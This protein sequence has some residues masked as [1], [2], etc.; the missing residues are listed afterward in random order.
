MSRM[1]SSN[2]LE[3]DAWIEQQLISGSRLVKYVLPAF[4]YVVT[5]II[6]MLLAL[7]LVLAIVELGAAIAAALD[8]DMRA[9]SN[10]GE[11]SVMCT[12]PQAKA[13]FLKGNRHAEDQFQRNA[14]RREMDSTWPTY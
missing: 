7:L 1:Q 8:H 9:S 5:G 13:F 10:S 2:V 14:H 6:A 11:R 12:S 4:R 3:V